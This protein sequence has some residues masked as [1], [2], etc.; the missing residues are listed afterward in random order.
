MPEIFAD[1]V[2]APVVSTSQTSRGERNSALRATMSGPWL[3]ERAADLAGRAE[4]YLDE[5]PLPERWEVLPTVLDMTTALATYLCLGAH[6]ETLLDTSR[7]LRA[8]TPDA[9]AHGPRRFARRSNAAGRFENEA[10]RTGDCIRTLLQDV[11]AATD[12]APRDVLGHLVHGDGAPSGWRDD[13]RVEALW[14]LLYTAQTAPA[15]CTAWL[16]YLLAGHPEIQ[17]EVRGEALRSSPGDSCTGSTSMLRH[18]TQE[19]LRMFPPT[20]LLGRV[21]RQPVEIAGHRLS[22]GEQVRVA[23]QLIHRD[24]REFPAPDTFNPARWSTQSSAT[25]PPL[26]AFLPF[27][28]GPMFCKGTTWVYALASIST[29][30]ILR[31][32]RLTGLRAPRPRPRSAAH[33]EPTG[34]VLRCRP[35]DH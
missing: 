32:Y 26:D 14:L 17:D 30:A 10:R 35:A 2:Q 7:R 9:L 16:L 24:P 11:P 23:V 22:P 21:A 27:G 31:R 6:S 33:L 3:R 12:G 28:A 29:T 4:A 20:W 5:H 8:A 15:L 13:E 1:T 25:R 34:L 19:S 18:S